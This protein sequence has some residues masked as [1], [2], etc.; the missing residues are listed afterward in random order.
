MR[1]HGEESPIKLMWNYI[2]GEGFILIDSAFEDLP[3]VTK[4]DMLKDWITELQEEYDEQREF[5]FGDDDA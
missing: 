2:S 1:T 5:A 3:D 4:L